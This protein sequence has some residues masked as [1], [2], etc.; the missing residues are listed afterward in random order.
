MDA[1]GGA[2]KVLKMLAAK[3]S[4]G[5]CESATPGADSK[6]GL[7]SMAADGNQTKAE[8]APAAT[9]IPED[10]KKEGVVA[11]RKVEQLACA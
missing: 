10:K 8:Q 2:G 6:I 9:E 7:P 1:A 4:H 3:V 11:R 5:P